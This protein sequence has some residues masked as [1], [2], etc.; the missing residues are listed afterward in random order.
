MKTPLF[1]KS[2]AGESQVRTFDETVA[3]QHEELIEEMG[4]DPSKAGLP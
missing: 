4:K 1:T 3:E 2:D